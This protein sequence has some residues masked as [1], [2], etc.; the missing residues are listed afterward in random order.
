MRSF[1]LLAGNAVV[2]LGAATPAEIQRGDECIQDDLLNC[3]SSSLVQASQFCTNSIVTATA[4][5]EVVTVTPTV[6]ITDAITETATVTETPQ[7][8]GKRRKRGCSPRPPL[9]CLRSFATS[10]EPFQFASACSCIGI[11]TTTEFATVTADVTNTIV[12]TPTVTEYVTVSLPPSVDESTSEPILEPTTTSEPIPEPTTTS[13]PILESTTTSEPIPEPTTTSEPILESTTTSELEVST[14]TTVSTSESATPSTPPPLIANGDF[15]KGSLEGWTV[16]LT[17]PGGAVGSAVQYGASY[18]MEL[19]SS[20]FLRNSA[21]AI[22]ASQTV[23]CEPGS[24]YRLTFLLSIVSSYTNGNPWSV[25]LGSTTIA[26]GAGSSTAWR[27]FTYTFVCSSTEAVNN[28]NFRLQSN[29]NRA[30]RMM[31]D[32][33]AVTPLF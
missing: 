27:Q 26:S 28:L 21:S 30:A 19:Y 18:V 16:T 2:I 1:F 23:Q 22:T 6:I 5:T 13:E 14:T 31:V 15:E 32:N 33:V 9:N 25:V 11:T 17:A 7:L 24:S 12:E 4:T 8:R 20:Y 10:V 3:F 29:N